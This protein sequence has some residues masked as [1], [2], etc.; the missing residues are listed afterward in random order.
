MENS[1]DHN[2]CRPNAN[3]QKP[4]LDTS[5]CKHFKRHTIVTVA[6]LYLAVRLLM[7]HFNST[8]NSEEPDQSG[9][10]KA[11]AKHEAGFLTV[12]VR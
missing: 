6:R 11:K 4:V 12:Y 8:E 10:S 9:Y 5:G 1:W 2:R 3:S 7:Q